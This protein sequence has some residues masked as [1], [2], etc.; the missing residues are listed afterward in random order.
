MLMKQNVN[1]I[2][3][4]IDDE[5]NTLNTIALNIAYSNLIKERFTNYISAEE[6]VFS[7]NQEMAYNNIQNTKVLIDMLTAILGPNQ[8]VVQIYL[9]SLDKGE[10]KKPIPYL[11]KKIKN[12]VK[13]YGEEIYIFDQNGK[14]IYPDFFNSD[15]SSYFSSISYNEKPKSSDDVITNKYD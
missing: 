11:I 6:N 7:T 15:Y 12:I 3:S 5:A 14:S 10:V 1:T 4:N 2:S 8:P 9:Y 13:S